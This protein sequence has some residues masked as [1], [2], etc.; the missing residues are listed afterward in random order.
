MLL[1]E[2]KHRELLNQ[3]CELRELIEEQ[4]KHREL[5]NQ[6]FELQKLVKDQKKDCELHNQMSELRQLMMDVKGKLSDEKGI[7]VPSITIESAN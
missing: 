3:M 4:K 6:M 2:Q 5:F 1:L 7:T